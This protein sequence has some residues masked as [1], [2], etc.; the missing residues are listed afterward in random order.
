MGEKSYLSEE[1]QFKKIL[2]NDEIQRIKDPKLQEI[3]R[4]Y[5][6]LRHKVFLDEHGI[7]DWEIGNVHDK[8]IKEEQEELRKYKLSLT[9]DKNEQ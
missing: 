5:W 7:P 8:L 6:N 9:E 1:E 2:S 4:R 3:R